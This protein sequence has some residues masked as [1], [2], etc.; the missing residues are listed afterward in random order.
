MGGTQVM[1]RGIAVVGIAA[2]SLL[3]TQTRP[4]HLRRD[5]RQD[6]RQLREQRRR[7]RQSSLRMARQNGTK[8]V[9]GPA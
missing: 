8:S 3:L 7:F 5:F 2:G 6:H 9:A 4:H 1:R